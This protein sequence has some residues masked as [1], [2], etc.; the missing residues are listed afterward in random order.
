M[1][2]LTLILFYQL[3]KKFSKENLKKNSLKILFIYLLHYPKGHK[4][5]ISFGTI[6]VIT[7]DNDL[8]Y[9]NC[10]SESGSSGGPLINLINMKLI[11]I[12]TG[13]K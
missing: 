5:N 2:F 9:H 11:G 7:E 6:K 1:N 4:S 13:D 12:H 8:I 3:M 10:G